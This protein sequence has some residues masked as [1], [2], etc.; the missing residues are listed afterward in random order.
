M[1]ADTAMAVGTDLY[2]E[3]LVAKDYL[4]LAVDG[5]RKRRVE[6]LDGSNLVVSKS[7]GII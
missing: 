1:T 7:I 2:I 4:F 3:I 5:I 6:W